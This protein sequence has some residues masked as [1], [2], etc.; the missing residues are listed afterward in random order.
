VKPIVEKIKSTD[1]RFDKELFEK[2]LEQAAE[3]E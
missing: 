1:F 3:R 2:V